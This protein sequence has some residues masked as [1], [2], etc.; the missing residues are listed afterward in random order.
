MR[1]RSSKPS[2][3]GSTRAHSRRR[4]TS[5]TRR[6]PAIPTSTLGSSKNPTPKPV[7]ST[8]PSRF[9]ACQVVVGSPR[10]SIPPSTP[11]PP[12]MIPVRIRESGRIAAISLV[13][14]FP[15][16]PK[17]PLGPDSLGSVLS[18]LHY[19][20]VCVILDREVAPWQTR[21]FDNELATLRS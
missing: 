14:H 18:A 19:F 6:S 3:R 9:A 5:S 4:K 8:R 7:G 17:A 11:G 2:R 16:P 12:S 10:L 1:A 13:S 15:A 21:S 20:T